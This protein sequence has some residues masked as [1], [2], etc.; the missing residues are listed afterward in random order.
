MKLILKDVCKEIKKKAILSHISL[1]LTSGNVY[2]FVGENGSGK[3]ML[4]R[5][6]SGL[7]DLTSGTVT[8]DD[9]T[10]LE[11]RDMYAFCEYVEN[12]W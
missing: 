10:K 6:I 9:G 11:I 2:A 8:L 7:M 1:E 5:A 4:F 12:R 3:T